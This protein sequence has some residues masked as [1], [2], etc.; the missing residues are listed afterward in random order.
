AILLGFGIR[1]FYALVSLTLSIFVTAT[2]VSEFH[3]GARAR[4]RTN[5]EGYGMAIIRLLQ[6]NKRRYG[7]YIV[8]FGIV[9]LFVGLTG[10]AFDAEKEGHLKPGE[11]MNIRSYTLTYKGYKTLEDPN[12]VVWQAEMDVFKGGQK[13][14][15]I[16]PNKHY[17]PVQ[18]Q[19]TTEVVL[20]ST[21]QEDLYVVLAQPNDDQSAVF[22]VYINPL[23]NLVWLS[24]LIV[25]LGTFIILLPDGTDRTKRMPV[26]R[27]SAEKVANSEVT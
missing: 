7:G 23:V 15:T 21:L 24:G 2:I 17:Y 3:R 26:R 11:S 27:V 19:P 22:K 18:E 25:T 6:R 10:K 16:Y 4:M 20:R 5:N 1:H 14:K 13:V 9:V 12:K 8:H